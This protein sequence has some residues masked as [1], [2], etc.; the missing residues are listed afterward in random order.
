MEELLNC[1]MEICCAAT[2]E[3]PS[4]EAVAALIEMFK[5]DNCHTKEDCARMVFE[6]FT[7]APRSFLA[8][9]QEIARLAK[10]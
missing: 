8:V 7:L 9:K 2:V 3:T 1:V 4:P 10:A 5:R 6:Y